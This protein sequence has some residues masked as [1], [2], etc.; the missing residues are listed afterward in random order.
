[1]PPTASRLLKQADKHKLTPEELIPFLL[2]QSGLC[3]SEPSGDLS[4]ESEPALSVSE[5][6][7]SLRKYQQP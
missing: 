1:M 4:A 2:A 5:N 3:Q 6:Y 7:S